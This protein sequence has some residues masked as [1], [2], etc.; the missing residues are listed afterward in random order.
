MPDDALVRLP[1]SMPADTVGADETLMKLALVVVFD[2]PG[3]VTVSI[4][5]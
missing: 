2:P 5:E 3:P 4:T 1:E